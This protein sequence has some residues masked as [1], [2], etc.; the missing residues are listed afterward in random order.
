M[1]GIATPVTEMLSDA[2]PTVRT[3]LRSVSIPVSNSSRRMPYWETPSSMAFCSAVRG[4]T[5]CCKSGHSTPSTEGPSMMPPSNMPITDGCPIR[6]MISPKR[7]PT[8]ISVMS[9][10]RKTTSDASLF[11]AASEGALL[12]ARIAAVQ[13]PTR[14]LSRAAATI[15]V[16]Q[17]MGA[18]GPSIRPN[19]NCSRQLR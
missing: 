10:A 4:K 14:A 15:G 3:S 6:F 16:E 19:R 5:A 13:R 9:W 8:S 2:L 1:N 11:S 18:R 12:S 7:R 17:V